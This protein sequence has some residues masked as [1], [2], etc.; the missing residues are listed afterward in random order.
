M[1]FYLKFIMGIKSVALRVKLPVT[2]AA[3]YFDLIGLD[4]GYSFQSSSLKTH[5]TI[6]KGDFEADAALF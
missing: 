4:S 2:L 5:V 3:I 1:E 6:D